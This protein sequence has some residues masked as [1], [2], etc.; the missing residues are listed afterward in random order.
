ML[1]VIWILKACMLFMFARMTLGTTHSKG[2]KFVGAYVLLGWIAVQIAFFTACRPFSGYWA[3][4]PPNSQCTTLEH[5]AIVQ[6]AFNLSSDF[7]II[8]VPVPMIVSLSLPLKQK[9]GLGVLFGMGTF[10][11]S[12]SLVSPSPFPPFTNTNRLQIVAAILTKVY[13]LSD[14]Y[15]T[16]YMLWYVREASVAVY[17]ANLP[18]IWPLLLEHIRFLR[19]HTSSYITNPSKL[20]KYGYGSQYGNMSSQAPRSRIRTVADGDSDEIELGVGHTYA[21]SS[22][23]PRSIEERRMHLGGTARTSQDSNERV[24]HEGW[25]QMGV[26]QVDTKVEIQRNSWSARDVEGPQVDT[27]IHGGKGTS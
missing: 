15:A 8:T 12:S 18:G 14:I 27:H 9:I 1:N 20:P 16:T 3:V 19:E 17:V 2:I 13:N 22:E 24:L 23:K 5:Y 26:V 21:A 10:V 25:M 11:V 6:A 7:L 4:P